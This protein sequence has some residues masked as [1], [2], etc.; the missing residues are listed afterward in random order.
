LSSLLIMRFCGSAKRDLPRDRPEI[1]THALY[2]FGVGPTLADLRAALDDLLRGRRRYFATPSA[3]RV[4]QSNQTIPTLP[5]AGS[6]GIVGWE[7]VAACRTGF[8]HAKRTPDR[9]GLRSQGLFVCQSPIHRPRTE[10]SRIK[11]KRIKM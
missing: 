5:R 7:F 1:R 9:G 3:S 6:L 4:L 2:L 11:P 10:S 8:S